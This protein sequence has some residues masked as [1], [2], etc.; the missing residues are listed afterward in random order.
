[1]QAKNEQLPPAG[2]AEASIDRVEVAMGFVHESTEEQQLFSKAEATRAMLRTQINQAHSFWQQAPSA[3][4]SQ[5]QEQ[6]PVLDK[7]VFARR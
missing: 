3:P 7:R 5:A 2:A 1:M 4:H 6:P